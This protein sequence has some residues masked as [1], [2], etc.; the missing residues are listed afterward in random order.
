MYIIHCN[1]YIILEGDR[2]L[3]KIYYDVYMSVQHYGRG[4][5][6]E[7]DVNINFQ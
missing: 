6:Q 3:N 7:G 4:W 1:M 5:V 2:I